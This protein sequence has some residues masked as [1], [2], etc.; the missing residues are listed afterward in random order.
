MAAIQQ[1]DVSVSKSLVDKKWCQA[2]S[3]CVNEAPNSI[4]AIM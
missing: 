1:V 2:T 4:L 3:L